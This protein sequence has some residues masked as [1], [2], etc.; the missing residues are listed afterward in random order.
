[1]G[2]FHT[3]EKWEIY[4]KFCSKDLKEK[5]PFEGNW[6]RWEDNKVDLKEVRYELV[7]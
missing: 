7:K 1:M 4:K 5:K 3:C 2:Q 6:R